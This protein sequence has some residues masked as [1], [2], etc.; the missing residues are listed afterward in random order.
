MKLVFTSFPQ[1]DGATAAYIECCG[2]LIILMC[3]KCRQQIPDK[4]MRKRD[5][6]NK[7]NKV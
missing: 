2:D 4:L 7:M 1:M 5:F 6:I 3:H